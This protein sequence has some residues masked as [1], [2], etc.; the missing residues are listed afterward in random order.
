MFVLATFLLTM[1]T[2]TVAGVPAARRDQDAKTAVAAAEAGLEEYLA[3]LDADTNYWKNGNVDSAN[4]AL[5]DPSR[6]VIRGRIIPGTGTA[7][8]RFRYT[9]LTTPAQIAR[10]GVIRLKVTGSSSP[11]NSANPVERSLTASLTPK[12]FLSFIYLSDV[13]VTDPDLIGDD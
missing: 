13:E 1:V 10:S 3:R 11:G 9:L 8:A 4:P 7:G 6:P 12:G 5:Q 2:F